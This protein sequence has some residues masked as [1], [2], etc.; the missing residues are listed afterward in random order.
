MKYGKQL[1]PARWTQGDANAAK[2]K[3]VMRANVYNPVT[4][5][6]EA[7]VAY[8][9]SE[10]GKT[11]DGRKVRIFDSNGSPYHGVSIQTKAQNAISG[12]KND[13]GGTIL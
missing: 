11:A 9:G 6:Y 13:M 7:A 8:E 1:Q 2:G 10:F 5:K 3:G 4:R 12:K